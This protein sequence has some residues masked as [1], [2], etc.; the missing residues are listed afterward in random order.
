MRGRANRSTRASVLA[1]YGP[2][3][4]GK[5][6]RH[7]NPLADTADTTLVCID[8]ADHHDGLT[9]RT[10]PSFGVRPVGLGLMLVVALEE[11][12]RNDYDG[13]V[14]FSLFPHGCIALLVGRLAG[15]PVHLGI[16]GIDLDVHA[17]SS[18]RWIV[19]PLLRQF[20]AISVPG[21]AHRRQLESI[22]I[23]PQR[24]VVLANAIDTDR[25]TPA[26]PDGRTYD[27]LW[28]GR[29]GPEKDPMMFIDALARLRAMDGSF[30]AVM[31]GDGPLADDVGRAL[32]DRG[33]TDVV[34]R[35]GWVNDPVPFYRRS[36]VF[37]LTSRRDAL[38]L[39]LIEAMATGVAPVVPRVGNVTD[40]VEDGETGVVLD[41]PDP[42]S[43]A[44]TLARLHRDDGFRER[45]A[46]NAPRV[47]E[48]YSYDAARAD[49]E[50]I[51][52]VM[53]V[54]DRYRRPSPARRGVG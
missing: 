49:W 53:G 21:T 30:R 17:R 43:V 12:L 27:F 7:V 34:D 23:G 33:L 2:S 50:S 16:L 32:H 8:A 18:Y 15:L 42:Q 54:R 36:R 1:I 38:P 51:L 11:V 47:R 4:T 10:V 40:V 3:N 26:A 9:Y 5:I 29:F 45:L 31:L 14:S 19:R 22:G 20:D 35:P 44:A 46:D 28:V 6:E 48:R 37:V 41:D 39:T 25:F 13:V 24:T 52:R